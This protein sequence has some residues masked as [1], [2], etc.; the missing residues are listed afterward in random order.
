MK[1]TKRFFIGSVIFVLAIFQLLIGVVGFVV[2]VILKGLEWLRKTVDELSEELQK[3]A[4]RD[5]R[6]ELIQ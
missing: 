2:T 4:N 1:K 5:N 3:E 6:E